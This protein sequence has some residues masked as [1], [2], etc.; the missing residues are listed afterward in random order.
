MCP[1]HVGLE[2]RGVVGASSPISV[3]VVD[4]ISPSY[5]WSKPEVCLAD[6]I[7]AET[8]SAATGPEEPAIPIGAAGQDLPGAADRAQRRRRRTGSLRVAAARR[9]PGHAPVA[10][11][12]DV[13]HGRSLLVSDRPGRCSS[14]TPW[15][16]VGIGLVGVGWM[17]RVHSVAYRR[18]R[19]HFPDCPGVARLVIAADEDPERAGRGRAA[20][21]RALDRQLAG[22]RRRSRG[23]GRQH[24]DPQP[25]APRRRGGRGPGGQA[26]LGRE[27]GR[28]LPS[29][30][31]AVAEAVAGAGVR[32]V[33]GFNYRHAPAVRHARELIDSGA[34]GDVS[35]FRSQWI[36]AYAADPRGVL[37]WRFLRDEAGLGILGDLGSHAVDLAQHLL[38]PIASVT[39]HTDTIVRERPLPSSA[40][41]HFALV[42]GGPRGTVENGRR[43]EHRPVCERCDG[44]DRDEPRRRRP[45][46]PLRLRGARLPRRRRV[47]LRAHERTAHISTRLTRG[48]RV[49]PCLDGAAA[50]RSAGFQPGPGL[51]GIRRPEGGRGRRSSSVVDGEQ[52]EP[53][54]R[55]ALAAAEVVAAM[56]R[57]SSTG[58][59]EPA[60]D[61]ALPG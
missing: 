16:A 1:P 23:R 26:C 33:V 7:V 39:A 29:G 13:R 36:A 2:V 22:G 38:G 54:L 8:P 37:S 20:R 43:M 35:H 40:G 5:A 18:C 15:R 42:D 27:A 17:G 14:V 47:G 46:G 60:G 6:R 58:A 34:V 41:T 48:L 61:V 10:D 56:A 3:T 55:E 59:W 53:G 25:A 32:S 44:N 57:S 24:R 19:D 21:V 9:R 50:R 45:A 12:G 49:Y 11:D 30:T 31:A 51:D 28:P 52:R 4:R